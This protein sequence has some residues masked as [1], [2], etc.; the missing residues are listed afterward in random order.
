MVLLQTSGPE[1]PGDVDDPVRG[2]PFPVVSSDACVVYVEITLRP[3]SFA[4]IDVDQQ[5]RRLFSSGRIGG[6]E[7]QGD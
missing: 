5:S 2:Y 1:R 6:K 4:V 3:K 7:P